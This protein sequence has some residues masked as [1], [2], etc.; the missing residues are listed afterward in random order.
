MDN[1]DIAEKDNA[2]MFAE[3]QRKRIGVGGYET[4]P[5]EQRKCVVC[6]KLIPLKRLLIVPNTNYC[7]DCLRKIE[8]DLK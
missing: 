2:T 5:N 7:V 1:A 8:N 3:W 4:D 6:G